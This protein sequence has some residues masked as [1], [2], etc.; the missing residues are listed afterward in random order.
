MFGFRLL[1]APRLGI[2]HWRTAATLTAGILLGLALCAAFL[3]AAGV[4]AADLADEFLVYTFGNTAGLD[5]T[6]TRA[7]PLMLVG[8]SVGVGL[9]VRFWNIGV[10][11]QIW[12]GAIGATAVVLYGVG[13]LALHLPIMFLAAAA[14]GGLWCGFAALARLRLRADEV[15]VTLLMNYVGYLIAQQLLY[16]AWRNPEDAYPTSRSFAPG[17]ERLPVLLFGHVHAGLLIAFGAMLFC[18]WLCSFS[19]FGVMARA[20]AA[21]PVAARAMGIPVGRIVFLTAVLA[22][23]LAGIAGFALVAGEEYKLTQ[24][25][26]QDYIFPS[27][28]IA[29]LGRSHPAGI[30]IAAI[31]VAGL[32]TAGDSLKAFYQLPGAVIITLEAILLLT[33]SAFDFFLRYRVGLVRRLPRTPS[34]EPSAGSG[35]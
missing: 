4:P 6:M 20:I 35:G 2:S 33:V 17:F 29:Y 1:L 31:A 27:I 11:G 18:W 13:P 21:N 26:G 22:G 3:V 19:P 24:F 12:V 10:E 7:I 15:I 32:Y 9:R 8:L 30:A 28:V 14:F 23:A 34:L 5:Q 16:G 25:V